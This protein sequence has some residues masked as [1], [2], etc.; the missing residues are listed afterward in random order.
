[1][2]KIRKGKYSGKIGNVVFVDSKYGGVVRSQPSRP[3]CPTMARLRPRSALSLVAQTWRTLTPTQFA[4]WEAA[5]QKLKR[6]LSKGARCPKDG[7]HLFCKINCVRV[8]AQEPLTKDPP[9]FEKIKP[10][11]IGELEILNR[12]GEI[13]LRV[14]VPRAPAQYTF[15]LGAPGCSAGRSFPPRRP[16]ILGRLPKAVGGWSD[17]T[18]L[19]RTAY[20]VPAVG[21]KVFIQTRQMIGGWEDDFKETSAVVPQ[22]E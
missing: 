13:T 6:R 11:P 1:M 15:V 17:F 19:Y 9:K 12:G 22:A 20:G 4:A 21:Q 10:N 5:V 14:R 16:A 7:Y 8:A 2:A 3:G 18:E